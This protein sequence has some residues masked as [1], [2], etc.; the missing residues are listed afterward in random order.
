M[1]L[2]KKTMSLLS[3]V[4]SGMLIISAVP[5]I[6]ASL[7]LSA[8]AADTCVVNTSKT[9][10][11]IKGFGG[12]NLP[13]WTG[14]DLT[15][16]QRKSAFGNGNGQLGLSIVRVYVNDDKNQ[17]NKALATAKYA[18][19][20]GA[21]VFATPWNPPA[22]MCETFS[23][24][25]D[26]DAKRLKKSSYAAYAQHLNDFYHYMKDNGVNLY[27]I[28]IQNEPDWGSDWTWMTESECVDFLANYADKIDCPVMSPES[29][30]Y[31]KSYYNAILNNSKA[32][33]NTDIFGTHFYGTSRS[34]MDF[35]ALENCGKEIF[36]TEVYV[37]NSTSDADKFPE[38]LDVCEN[39]HN[40]LVVGNMNAYVWW[41]IRRSYGLIKENSNVSK[42]GYCLAQ[43]SK[44]V[45]PG[46]VR[47]DATEQPS[48]KVYVSAY[49][50]SKNQVTIVAVNKSTTGY[51]QNF[52]L[53]S[54]TITDVDRYRTSS[55]ENLALT[56][57]LPSNGGSFNVQLPAS[58]VS[59]FVVTVNGNNQPTT[60]PAT[61][62]S[63]NQTTAKSTTTKPVTQTTT[64]PSANSSYLFRNTFENGVEDWT[65]RGSNTLGLS[66][67]TA[68]AGKNALLVSKRT[69]SWNGAQKSLSTSTFV[70]GNTYGFSAYVNY[71]D[72]NTNS[73]TFNL[74][75]QYK[76]STGTIKYSN[77]ATK[78]VTKGTYTKLVNSN[79]KI[80]SGAS[81]IHLIVE[82][83]KDTMNFYVDEVIGAKAG[84][85]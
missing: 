11:T 1:N 65:A 26:A 51:S 81:D 60:Q 76:D 10:Q 53:S 3:V 31:N 44:F 85:L 48:S 46:D 5:Q 33:A 68:F 78:S 19:S 21:I 61:T 59:T 52:S 38:A 40:G 4:M 64:K 32:Y 8:S 24:S 69:S 34:N 36:M 41:Y 66:G 20:Q 12:M 37:P 29:F 16:G 35:P 9:Y 14:S 63:A 23:K 55:N 6:P 58:S 47:V 13:E 71:L 39:I 73:S 43:Y 30:S 57:N 72:G 17:W 75:L 70:P 15:D 84:Q 2:L 77:I 45:R 62:K 80:P 7:P 27:A 56:E 50:N 83:S 74:T 79:Y 82:T 22:S 25:N 67:R 28:S 54:G 18:Q 42:R 49:K